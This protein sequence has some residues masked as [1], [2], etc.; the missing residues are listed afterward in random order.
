M[1]AKSKKNTKNKNKSTTDSKKKTVKPANKGVKKAVKPVS[2]GVNK[3]IKDIKDK[4]KNLLLKHPE[5]INNAKNLFRNENGTTI[6]EEAV[7]R[8]D[9]GP[10]DIRTQYDVSAEDINKIAKEAKSNLDETLLKYDPVVAREDALNKTIW[11]KDEGKF[12]AKINASTFALILDAMGEGSTSKKASED[13]AEEAAPEVNEEGRTD[14]Q[15][16]HID[17]VE[18]GIKQSKGGEGLSGAQVD[19]ILKE[20]AEKKENKT[21]EINNAPKEEPKEEPKEDA[22]KDKQEDGMSDSKEANSEQIILDVEKVDGG[23]LMENGIVIDQKQLDAFKTSKPDA[24]V[25]IKS[26][27]EKSASSEDIVSAL[28]V[29]AGDLEAEKDPELFKI[30][31]Q[32]DGICD[33]LEGKEGATLKSDPDEAYMKK[34]FKGD[35]QQSDSDEGY[36]KKD[37]SGDDTK[38]VKKVVKKAS[39][40][41]PYQIK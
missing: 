6:V 39:D 9:K 35:V 18:K 36:M 34:Y 22:G 8:G 29:V 14:D 13:K 3:G 30:A 31:Y 23:Y 1:S 24:K 5:L 10:S 27:S 21:E 11:S 7:V 28:E 2:K 41:L 38:E 26:A 19:K 12:A 37:M 15:E 4:A 17:K 32:I 20:R 33:F 25:N 40:Q 16:T